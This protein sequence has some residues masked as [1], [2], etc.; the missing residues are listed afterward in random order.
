MNRE[1]NESEGSQQDQTKIEKIEKAI[2]YCDGQAKCF[3]IEYTKFT[4]LEGYFFY[5]EMSINDVGWKL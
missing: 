1:I 3:S 2:E 5:N 4:S